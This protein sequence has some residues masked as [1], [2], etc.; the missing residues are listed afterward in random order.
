MAAAAKEVEVTQSALGDVIRLAR[1]GRGELRAA[2]QYYPLMYFVDKNYSST[3]QTCSGEIVEKPIVGESID[4]CASACDSAIHSCVGFSY[5]GTG[6]TSLCF[7][8]S[9]LKSAVYYT[10]CKTKEETSLFQNKEPSKC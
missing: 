6:T 9:S 2:A 7:L 10:G 5:F 8:F 3:M 1:P 4:G